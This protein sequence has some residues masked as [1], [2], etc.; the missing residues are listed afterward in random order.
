MKSS[1]LSRDFP[2]KVVT[3]GCLIKWEKD[4]SIGGLYG[5]GGTGGVDGDGGSGGRIYG[6]SGGRM[7]GGCIDGG[8]GSS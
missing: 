4:T 1:I 7:Y 3:G 5:D 8:G 2:W 6:G